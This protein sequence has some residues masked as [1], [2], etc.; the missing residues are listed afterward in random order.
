MRQKH[1]WGAMDVLVNV[2]RLVKEHVMVDV[3][4]HANMIVQVDVKLDA[5]IHARIPAQDVAQE[6]VSDNCVLY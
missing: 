1:Q 3:K 6:L 4:A 5:E 2:W